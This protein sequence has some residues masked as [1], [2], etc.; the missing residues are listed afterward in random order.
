MLVLVITLV[1]FRATTPR[2]RLADVELTGATTG[3]GLRLTGRVSVSNRNFA[4][5]EFESSLATIRAADGMYAGRFVIHDGRV[6]ARSTARVDVVA[7]LSRPSTGN[8]SS[9]YWV[10]S[11]LKG[12]VRVLRVFRR[13]RL[14]VLNCTMTVDLATNGVRNLRCY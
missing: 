1:F 2:A 12:R 7:D 3:G 6:R 11:R 14:T 5:Y 9:D 8:G 10:E 13:N 4:R